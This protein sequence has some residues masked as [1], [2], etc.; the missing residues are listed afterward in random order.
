MS[1]KT[2]AAKQP[3]I[4]Q[5]MAVLTASLKTLRKTQDKGQLSQNDQLL[6]AV[7]ESTVTLTTSVANNVER[8]AEIIK[9]QQQTIANQQQTL[10]NTNQT[11]TQ[12]VGMIQAMTGVD[13]QVKA[14]DVHTDP[15]QEPI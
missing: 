4:E 8:F 5:T 12:L 3:D 6:L 11:L 1:K 10:V 14:G 15:E 2:D 13:I 7:C 9:T